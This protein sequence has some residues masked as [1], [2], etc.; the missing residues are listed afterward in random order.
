MP[1]FK[2]RELAWHIG[3]IFFAYLLHFRLNSLFNK[4]LYVRVSLDSNVSTSH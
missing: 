4:E 1:N 3:Y 2:T